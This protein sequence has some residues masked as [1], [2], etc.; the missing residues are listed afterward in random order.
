MIEADEE[1]P[2]SLQKTAKKEKREKNEALFKKRCRLMRK[3]SKKD[4]EKRAKEEYESHECPF[5][6]IKGQNRRPMEY[7]SDL[8]ECHRVKSIS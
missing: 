8:F 7:K 5:L 1:N 3:S 2:G 4:E 6:L